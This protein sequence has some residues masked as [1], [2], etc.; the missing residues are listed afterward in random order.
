MPLSC[1]LRQVLLSFLHFP[2]HDFF[3]SCNLLFLPLWL[4]IIQPIT[5]LG[6]L[7]LF[8]SLLFVLLMRI[9]NDAHENLFFAEIKI[10][11]NYCFYNPEDALVFA[12]Q[13][14]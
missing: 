1:L 9:C 12:L 13:A 14:E 10:S 7:A 6:H 8:F 4:V 11:S 3:Q 2:L 5:L